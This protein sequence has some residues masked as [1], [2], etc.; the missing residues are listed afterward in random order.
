MTEQKN[1]VAEAHDG[2]VY[3]QV[4]Q[5]FLKNR[6]MILGVLAVLVIGIG[7]YFGYKKFIQE[8]KELDAR[9]KITIAQGYFANDSLDLA[10]NGDGIN[11]G[12][13][14]ISSSY[15]NTATGNLCQYYIGVIYLKQEQTDLAIE[16]LGKYKPGTDELKGVTHMLL[17]HAWADKGDNTKAVA[18]YKEAGK[19]AKND[20]YSP[21][22]YKMAGDLLLVMEDYSQALDMYKLIK[23]EYPLSE[24]GQNIDK[25]IAYA[26]TKMGK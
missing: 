19:S 2:D 21:Y 16:H 5:F 7:G 23:K 9:N 24:E 18:E 13:L 15:K 10:L 12:F 25:E 6:N 8:P 1:A 14:A 11:P 26:E 17:G 20:M 22:Y 3:R 4:E